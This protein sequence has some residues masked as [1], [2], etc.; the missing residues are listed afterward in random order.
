L[1]RTDGFAEPGVQRQV[2]ERQIAEVTGDG[3]AIGA[4]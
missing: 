1:H 3:E 4:E 2:R